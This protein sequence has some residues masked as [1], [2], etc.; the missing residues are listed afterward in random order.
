MP[1]KSA[2]W[3]FIIVGIYL[4]VQIA[5]FGVTVA[6]NTIHLKMAKETLSQ[7]FEILSEQLEEYH[8][9]ETLY[10]YWTNRNT[11]A[12]KAQLLYELEPIL[13]TRDDVKDVLLAIEELTEALQQ[14]AFG[15]KAYYEN[16]R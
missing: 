8:D 9:C 5:T 16:R 11:K 13:P 7:Q 1:T 12:V 15:C 10:A 14:V 6:L 4:L 2:A 3:C